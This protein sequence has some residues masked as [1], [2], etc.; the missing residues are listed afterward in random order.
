MYHG[1]TE[2]SLCPHLS[3][4]NDKN[5][6]KPTGNSTLL[7]NM[8]HDTKTWDGF[9]KFEKDSSDTTDQITSED[10]DSQV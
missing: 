2:P 3:R 4:T 5:I 1:H 10:Y 6:S 9:F 7:K 8:D